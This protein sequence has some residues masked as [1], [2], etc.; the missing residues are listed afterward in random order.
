MEQMWSSL[1]KLLPLPDHT[2][3]YCAHEYTQVRC[4]LQGLL[5][6]SAQPAVR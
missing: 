1:S 6:R 3:V 4:A 2:R 5:G